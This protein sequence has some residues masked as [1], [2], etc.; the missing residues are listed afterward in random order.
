MNV[1]DLILLVAILVFAVIGWR[2]GF[3]YGLFGLVGFL[4]GAGI[5]LFLVPRMLA[6]WGPGL[7]RAIV[8]VALVFVLAVFGQV[9]IGYFG[10][11]LKEAVTWRPAVML[12]A[13]L[14]AILS[15]VSMLL[16]VWL[17]A[18]VSVPAGHNPLSRAVRSSYVLGIVN[19]VIPSSASNATGSIQ[20]L[21]NSAGFPTVFAGIAPEPVR[22]V[23]AP[24][25]AILATRPVAR[26]A[27]NVVKITGVAASCGR[28]LEGS[29]FVFAPE[30]VMTNAHVVAGVSSP[31]VFMAGAHRGFQGKIVYFDPKLD[32]A[33]LDVPGLKAR[34]LPIGISV[35]NGQDV[36]V[37]G[38]PND[39][40]LSAVPGRVRN[41]LVARGHDI[42]GEGTVLRQVIS[43]RA[44]IQPGNSGGP[45]LN[46]QGQVVG[47]VFAASADTA[48]TGYAMTMK[49]T[50]PAIA[51]AASAT[52]P[53]NSGR[54]A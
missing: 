28:G 46:D 2:R 10:K 1:V 52:A 47:I 27:A 39:G 23:G 8:A 34:P 14:G 42:Y 6:G 20:A 54:C 15:V 49:L 11:R 9:G 21:V 12:D 5:G 22:P 18:S 32:I 38:Y 26:S 43:L 19:D 44:S 40:N 31:T 29:G 24:N 50:A 37:V 16:V 35:H 7:G 30:R 4:V 33:I 13:S 25:A 45:V 36:A 48:D 53:V 41:V 17:I 3:L 51:A